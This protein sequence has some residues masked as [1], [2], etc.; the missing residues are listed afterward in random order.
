MVITAGWC[1]PVPGVMDGVGGQGRQNLLWGGQCCNFLLGF[2][3]VLTDGPKSFTDVRRLPLPEAAV[4]S[5]EI[6]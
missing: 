1:P 6:V 5:R 2:L 4:N 3:N